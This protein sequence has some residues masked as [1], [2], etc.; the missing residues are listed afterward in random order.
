MCDGEISS[1]SWPLHTIP[2][3]AMLL[4]LHCMSPELAPTTVISEPGLLL[5]IEM[6][7]GDAPQLTT[8]TTF[9]L[10]L[11]PSALCRRH[12]HSGRPA[13][14][15]ASTYFAGCS[16]FRYGPSTFWR[17]L[18]IRSA[19]SI[20][21]NRAISPFASSSRPASAQ[22]AAP[23]RSA[24]GY[25]AALAMPSLPMIP[26]HHNGQQRNEHAQS[27][28]GDLDRAIPFL[29][30]SLSLSAAANIM[31]YARQCRINLGHAYVLAR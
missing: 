13:F 11:T 14:R 8:P 12:S 17:T 26:L 27:H 31:G 18:E 20:S 10:A 15:R 23:M 24:R 29:E 25:S 6:L 30:R 1:R 4:F 7:W 28:K 22:L 3:N 16:G 19:G 5:R 21:S 9:T 2:R